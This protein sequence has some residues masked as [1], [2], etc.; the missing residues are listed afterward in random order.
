MTDDAISLNQL[1]R[2]FLD[3]IAGQSAAS[4]RNYRHRLKDFLERYGEYTPRQV[5]RRHINRWHEWLKGRDLAGPTR[6]GYRQG[7]RAFFNWLVAEGYID[8]NPTDHLKIGSYL[9]ASQKLPPEEH[10]ERI[11][12][13]V[14]GWLEER[15][16]ARQRVLANPWRASEALTRQ[17]YPES[18]VIRDA[19]IWLLARG[20]GPRSQ[21]ICN[22]RLSILR[23]SLERGPNDDGIYLTSSHGKT[24]ATVIRFDER[25]A[26]AL[27][28]WLES[29]PDAVADYAFV[30]AR[31]FSNGGYRQLTRS[32]LAHIMTRLAKTA[33]VPRPIYTHALRHRIGHLTTKAAGPKVAAMLLNHRDAATAATAIAFYHH[34]DE[35]DISRAMITLG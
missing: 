13:M 20:C 17:A 35:N 11:T 30:T 16:R 33:G 12:D 34:P 5:Q 25:T 22:L 6:A 27:R 19:A 29:R 9:P 1:F 26:Q 14:L 24:G 32:A 8:R 7:I 31:S 23:R 2:E 18:W 10:V 3:G 15:R 4:Q 28:D 21:E